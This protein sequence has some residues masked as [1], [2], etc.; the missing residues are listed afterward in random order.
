MVKKRP[1]VSLLLASSDQKVG[2]TLAEEA[3]VQYTRNIRTYLGKGKGVN[4]ADIVR[5][6]NI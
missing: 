4:N 2:K 3:S 1:D 5:C 6:L